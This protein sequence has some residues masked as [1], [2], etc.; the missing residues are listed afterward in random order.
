MFS[1]SLWF[2]LI[3][4][5]NLWVKSSSDRIPLSKVM[6]GLTLTGGIGNTVKIVHS[7]LVVSVL[8][9]NMAQSSSEIVEINFLMSTAFKRSPLMKNVVGFSMVTFSFFAPQYGHFLAFL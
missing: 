2:I 7:G 5:T 6:D 8:I 1:R 9:P 4:S 3:T